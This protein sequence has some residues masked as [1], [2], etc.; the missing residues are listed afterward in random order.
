MKQHHFYPVIHYKD[1]QTTLDNVAKATQAGCSGIF[2]IHM[3]GTDY[4]LDDAL[5]LIRDAY[6]GL[7][8][9]INRLAS[10]ALDSLHR[11]LAISA[12]MTWVDNCGI[13]SRGITDKAQR[14]STSLKL[15]PNHLFFGS[16]AFKY[17]APEPNPALAAQLAESCGFIPTTSGTATGVAADLE[18]IRSMALA[19]KHLG[20]ASGITPENV[21]DY[22]AYITHYLV[23]TGVSSSFHEFDLAKL[24]AVSSALNLQH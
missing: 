7:K 19:C 14:L 22:T 13:T 17:Q 12:D 2:L 5:V 20:I 6:P 21:L 10:T 1:T 18:K 24:P 16:V 8:I 4:L 23:A 11:N 9:G 15:H 3:E